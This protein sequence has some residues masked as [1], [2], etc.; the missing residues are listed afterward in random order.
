MGGKLFV[1]IK[2]DMHFFIFQENNIIEVAKKFKN[3]KDI[4]IAKID[5]SANEAPSQ[6]KVEGFPTIYYALPGRKTEPIKLEGKRDTEGLQ[7]FIEENSE[8]LKKKAKKEELWK[9]IG[10]ILI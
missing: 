7:K 5:G 8:I 3:E 10:I 9:F 4:V 1:R 2:Y 6:Y